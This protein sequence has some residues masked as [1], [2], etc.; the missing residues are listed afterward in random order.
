MNYEYREIYIEVGK[1]GWRELGSAL[2]ELPNDGW[3]LFMAV[4]V[5]GPTWGVWLGLTGG[6]TRAIIHYFRRPL[7]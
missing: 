5:I 2:N 3:E 1:K 4:P 7:A 6:R